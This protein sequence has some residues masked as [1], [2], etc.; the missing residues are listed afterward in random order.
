MA[1]VPKVLFMEQKYTCIFF[2][3]SRPQ[4]MIIDLYYTKPATLG[5]HKKREGKN[6][7]KKLKN[8]LVMFFL[9]AELQT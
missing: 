9:P 3:K 5:W 1:T 7:K 2:L 4:S 8:N 6:T